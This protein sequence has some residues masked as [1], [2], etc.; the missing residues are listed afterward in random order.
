M[1]TERL[2]KNK[3]IIPELNLFLFKN[4][5]S[6]VNYFAQVM[7]GTM[8]KTIKFTFPIL[9][10]CLAFTAKSQF[11]MTNNGATFYCSY[12][13]VV[14]SNGG[15]NNI[16]D[17][18]YNLG[19]FTIAGNFQNDGLIS[20]NGIYRV[21]G[22]WI[23]ND[24][25][26]CG[27]SIVY[28]DNTPG[29]HPPIVPDQ[30]IMGTKNTSFYDLTLVGLGKKSITLD[31]TVKHYLDLTD[32]ELAVDNHTMFVTNTDPLAIHRTSGYVSNLPDG[33]LN[34]SFGVI[35]AYLFPMGSDVNY[36]RYRPVELA[37]TTEDSISQYEVGFFNYNATNDGY[38]VHQKD[39]TIC[40]VDS[41][42]YHKI[43]KVFGKDTTVDI[44][45]YYNH[46][47]D[48][49]WD[50]MANW[51]L[52]N[53]N[54]WINML[55]TSQLYSPM[56]GIKKAGWHTWTNL[57]YA[58]IA[59]VPDSIQINGPPEVCFGTPA[60]YVAWGNVTDHYVWNVVG[61]HIVGDSTTNT[62]LVL[63]DSA[64]IGIIGVQEIEQWS[65]C[66]GLIS[67]FNVIVH[68]KPLAN[69]QVVPIDTSHIFAFDL[70]HFVD[71]SQ[72]AVQ[73][74]WE[75]GD[76]SPST[77]QSPYHVYQQIGSYNVCLTVSSIFN[78]IADT[79]KMV[80]VTEG[81]QI[82]NVFTPNGDG[83]NDYFNIEASGMTQF[84][85]QV[86]NRW[87]VLLFE[88]SSAYVKWDGKTISGDD[89]SDGTYYYI[90]NAKSDKQDYSRHGTVTL[91]RH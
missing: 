36:F 56:R 15:V 75:F 66:I 72:L 70:I 55:P 53:T 17:S 59:R 69:F 78:C 65:S 33:W 60:T 83:Y 34:R 24:T 20:G 57:P 25:F 44:T 50:G 16:G 88:S 91:L 35:S 67:H 30:L 79:C 89:A 38:N 87:G 52:S 8:V 47:M 29:G 5:C 42:F 28:M 63:W 71:A 10:I 62:I 22:H 40:L 39:N 19:N 18:L 58:L 51:N 7:S 49:P 32:R 77:Q 90:L 48:G 81:I 23:N 13:S 86:F 26:K 74:S 11:I 43:N 46:F 45:I 80:D 27:T 76:G 73:W 68:P 54:Q 41:L 12:G 31:D 4:I 9:L 85:L 61:G 64:G 82:P 6:F 84:H 21:G 37:T 14:W 3:T 2:L 1:N